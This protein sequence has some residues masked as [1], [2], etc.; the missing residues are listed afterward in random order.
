MPRLREVGIATVQDAA[1]AGTL[2]EVAG[3]VHVARST[4]VRWAVAAAVD[5]IQRLLSIGQRD[6]QGCITLLALASRRGDRAIHIDDRF[7]EE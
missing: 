2:T 3:P 5:Q 7:I 1:E 4:V 6:D